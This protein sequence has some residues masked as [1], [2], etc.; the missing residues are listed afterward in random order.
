MKKIFERLKFRSSFH[1]W[2]RRYR[3]S[4]TSGEGSYGRLAQFKGDVINNLIQ[5]HEIKKPLNLAA[6]MVINSHITN[7][8]N[9]PE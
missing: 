6:V 4:R 9:I 3:K 1:Y 8:R 7:F 2:E 5:S